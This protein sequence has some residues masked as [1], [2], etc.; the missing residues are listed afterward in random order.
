ME[1]GL[2]CCCQGDI[3]FRVFDFDDGTLLWERLLST[4]SV[5]MDGRVWE[6][7]YTQFANVVTYSNANTT[8]TMAAR[9]ATP[10][11]S[12]S[13]SYY[14]KSYD[15]ATGSLLT[16]SPEYTFAP[17][18]E[19]AGPFGSV[20][21]ESRYR[22]NS[23]GDAMFGTPAGAG[24]A[25]VS[26]SVISN[27]NNAPVEYRLTCTLADSATITLRSSPATSDAVFQITDSPATIQA[28]I[29]SAFSAVINSVTVTGTTIAT[30]M[31]SITIDWV[32]STTYLGS[33]VVS[34]TV[35]TKSSYIRNLETGQITTRGGYATSSSYSAHGVFV[36][37]GKIVRASATDA[38]STAKTVEC[39]DVTA[40]PWVRMWTDPITGAAIISGAGNGVYNVAARNGTTAA[41]TP[42]RGASQYSVVTWNEGGTRL[43][44]IDYAYAPRHLAISN[45]TDEIVAD[46]MNYDTYNE[47]Y[48]THT[49][50]ALAVA[51]LDG[52]SFDY[53][54]LGTANDTNNSH[55]AGFTGTALAAVTYRAS[56]TRT[57]GCDHA[58]ASEASGLSDPF[59]PANCYRAFYYIGTPTEFLVS[60]CEWRLQFLTIGGAD[61]AATSWFDETATMSDLNAE[62]LAIFGSDIDARQNVIADVWNTVPT[63][64]TQPLFWQS[65]LR[66][67]ARCARNASEATASGMDLILSANIYGQVKPLTVEVRDAVSIR[68]KN[69][70]AVSRFDESEIWARN[71]S[72]SRASAYCSGVLHDGRLY[73]KGANVPAEI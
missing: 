7:A 56:P 42:L 48:V 23:S 14:A 19:S 12:A 73:C 29:Q 43:G 49:G 2:G 70:A 53:H 25:P 65:A 59:A 13:R 11:G 67:S 40:S 69:I 17:Q 57:F 22:I 51:P 68:T 8:R 9:T 27:L 24:T 61:L 31:I 47:Q 72:L 71:Y 18:T 44:T 28:A 55:I 64:K 41:G 1:W 54:N 60:A 32:N 3:N 20:F 46:Y 66:V 26:L 39:W 6:F 63:Y 36:T 5:G 58:Q 10:Q 38:D 50:A 33:Y 37:E 21:I 62:L 52:S 16:T 15:G 4:P 30:G 35:F 45:N 34:S